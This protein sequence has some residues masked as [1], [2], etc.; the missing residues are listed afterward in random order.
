M[1][2]CTTTRTPDRCEGI[3]ISFPDVCMGCVWIY[4][5]TSPPCQVMAKARRKS[6][7]SSQSAENE[8]AVVVPLSATAFRDVVLYDEMGDVHQILDQ[9]H[10]V[11]HVTILGATALKS[12]D[13]RRYMGV[14]MRLCRTWCH[15]K[16]SEGAKLFTCGVF[17]QKS[18]HVYCE[19]RCRRYPGASWEFWW[20]CDVS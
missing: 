9:R 16:K 17:E 2:Y 14:H 15:L 4:S 12:V 7:I 6:H 5:D 10:L 13:C 11:L 18:N 3:Q 8:N 1:V 19:D 20:I